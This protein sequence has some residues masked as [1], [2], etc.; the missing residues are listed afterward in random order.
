MYLG[1]KR[2]LL[3]RRL[4]TPF[5]P[6]SGVI[7]FWD[8]L[9]PASITLNSG[10]VSA[11]AS[12]IGS[13]SLSQGTAAAQPAYQ[14]TGWDGV[15]PC[16]T[17]DGAATNG[18]I[19]S[20]ASGPFGANL[21]ALVWAERGTQQDGAGS[22][23]RPLLTSSNTSGG[24]A[25][26][27]HVLRPTADGGQTQFVVDVSAVGSVASTVTS[28]ANGSKALL[29]AKRT[30]GPTARLNGGAEGSAG[31]FG[32]TA[33]DTASAFELFGHSAIAARRF[34]GK[35]IGAMVFE[36]EP[37]TLIRQKAEGYGAW[38]Y[39]IPSKLPENHPYRYEVP[40]VGF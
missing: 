22:S 29:A 37:S 16:V 36:N 26:R 28:F 39:N 17:G 8:A 20:S 12:L 14:A 5:D 24:D 3:R 2:A 1:A 30:S 9:T 31:S 40:R 15:L 27:V 38:R 7:A 4:W 10:N 13:Y 35:I 25:W 21:Y 6:G 19:L 33:G 23:V 32:A 11:W 18:D 34:A